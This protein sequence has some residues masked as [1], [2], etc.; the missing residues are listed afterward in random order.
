MFFYHS[1]TNPYSYG[2]FQCTQAKDGNFDSRSPVS[3]LALSIAICLLA[4]GAS[5]SSL[6]PPAQIQPLAAILQ[7]NANPSEHLINE[8]REN[9]QMAQQAWRGCFRYLNG[10]LGH[11]D[12]ETG[13]IPRNLT[14]S[15]FWNAQD[16][17]ADNYPFMTLTAALLDRPRFET[18]MHQM[19]ETEIELTSRVDHLPDD[20]DFAKQGFR[21]D[22]VD[23]N[24]LIFGGSEYVKDGLMPLTE[25]LG[26][27]PWS[28]RMISITNSIWEHASVESPF[29]LI[30][31]DNQEINGE[32]MQVLVRLYFMTGEERYKQYAFRL[33]DYYLLENSPVDEDQLRLDDHGCEVIDGLAGAYYLASHTDQERYQRYQEPLYRL[34]DRVLEA[35]VNQDGL[36]YE[37][38]NPQSGEVI[39]SE[40]SDN[41]GYNYNAILNV[42]LLDDH[43]PY[44][45]ATASMLDALPAYVGYP[46][47]GAGADGYADAIEGGL[48]LY[49]RIPS[50]NARQWIE[51]SVP[52]LLDAV[53]PDGVVEGWHGDGNFARTALMV[54]L[55]K[56]QGVHIHPWRHDITLG[57]ARQNGQLVISI[58]TRWPWH[59][60]LRFDQPRHQ[61]ILGLPSD[62]PRINQFPEWFTASPDETYVWRQAGEPAQEIEGQT[63]I[64]GVPLEL[65]GGSE[66]IITI[67]QP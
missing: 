50:E 51:Q 17:A 62:F 10:W 49:N 24:R 57:A 28:Q 35:G 48:N 40:L 42:G 39:S 15:W 29:G 64:E 63:L 32:Q 47:E 6:A 19:L 23:M 43:Q 2:H 58:Q 14:R 54:G 46:W 25:W 5:A 53:G 55:W 41:W 30:P 16:A 44:I 65:G 22:E 11:R 36:V 37:V 38:I 60:T 4:P 3:L 13:L 18:T 20:Y 21:F 56:T 59:G 1:H 67:T 33:A 34:L 8:A 52:F 27:S 45:Q 26:E 12:P 7:S 66:A 9:G 61:T 31:S